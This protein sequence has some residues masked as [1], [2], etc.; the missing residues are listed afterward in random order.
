MEE[1]QKISV[2][3][4]D[5]IAVLAHS[6]SVKRAREFAMGINVCWFIL[7]KGQR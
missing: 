7:L 1:G 5:L 2:S 3:A 4:K 6:G